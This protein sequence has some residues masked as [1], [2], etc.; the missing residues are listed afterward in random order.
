M[1]DRYL[2]GEVRR[3][4]PEGP[5]PVVRLRERSETLGGGGNVAANLAALGCRVGL[6]SVRGNDEAGRRLA[7]L[8]ADR[9]IEA[10][11][12][13]DDRRPTVT[14]TRVIASA[15]QLFRLDEEETG[16]ID[17]GLCREMLQVVG[18]RLK[19]FRAL[20]LSDYGKGVLGTQG[21]CRQLIAMGKRQGIPVLVDPKG[22][23]WQRYRGAT[24][25]TPNTAELR[26][27]AG[28]PDTAARDELLAAAA[29]ICR[30]LDLDRLLLTRGARGMCL[31]G[32]SRGPYIVRARARE[33]FDVSGAGDTVVAVMAAGLAGGLGFEKSAHV[34]NLAAGIV[35]GKLGTQA[36]TSQE[37]ETALR[38]EESR[39]SGMP[40]KELSLESA[41]MQIKAWRA[42]GNRI[43]FT[44]GCFDLLHPGHINLLHQAKSLG[45]RL[46]VGVNTDASVRRLKGPR[47]PILSQQDRSALLSALGSVDLVLLFDEDTPLNL[48]SAIKPDILVKGADYRREDV[49]GGDVV[50]SY[51]GQVRLV[52]LLKGYSTTDITRRILSAG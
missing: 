21:V 42:A 6:V 1:L 39:N 14:K 28:L 11:L 20:I 23:D 13:T 37:L 51:G 10:R 49:V 33:V 15:Q 4:S 9:G 40:A 44:N 46:V 17:T 38:L 22:L 25:I 3:I 34:A 43:V 19:H 48:I 32:G 50:E 45:D 29:D 47:R 16:E 7:A 35:V 5:V 41:L 2:W 30:R 12:L 36:V 52:S 18:D 24:C 8:V 27:A 26:L 31:V